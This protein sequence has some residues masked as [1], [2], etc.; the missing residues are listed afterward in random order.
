[1]CLDSKYDL[2]FRETDGDMVCAAIEFPR[3]VE[4]GEPFVDLQTGYLYVA[5]SVSGVP[6]GNATIITSRGDKV[7]A[8]QLE[9]FRR[10]AGYTLSKEPTPLN[11]FFLIAESSQ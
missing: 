3:L 8:A 7:S 6:P 2:Y 5:K 9:D 11:D 1:L 4:K 10:R